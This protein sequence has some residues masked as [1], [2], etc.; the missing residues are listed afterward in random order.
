VNF[1]IIIYMKNVFIFSCFLVLS[2]FCVFSAKAEGI[3]PSLPN[4][5]SDLFKT[6]EKIN[7]DKN[8]QIFSIN[9]Q[10]IK[11]P[12]DLVKNFG[13][14]KDIWNKINLWLLQN[15]GISFSEIIRVV[16]NFF[17]WVLELFIKIL[18]ALISYLPV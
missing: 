11:A 13:W 16:V 5:V 8:S 14:L 3:I 18:K 10:G 7:I 9:T 17:V 12:G 15:V 2:L 1:D 6:F 4:E